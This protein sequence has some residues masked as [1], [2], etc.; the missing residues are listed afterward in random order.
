MTLS[1]RIIDQLVYE[2]KETMRATLTDPAVF[3]YFCSECGGDR[4]YGHFDGC[5]LESV[6]EFLDKFDNVIE[7]WVVAKRNALPENWLTAAEMLQRFHVSKPTLQSWRDK[8]LIHAI[9][10][11]PAT[12]TRPAAHYRFPPAEVERFEREFLN[13]KLGDPS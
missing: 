13:G 6:E 1:E 10:L 9:P 11:Q 8:K 12:D 3:T 7:Q 5:T 2:P 4:D